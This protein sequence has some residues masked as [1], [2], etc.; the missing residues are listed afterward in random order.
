MTKPKMIIFDYGQTLVQEKG[1]DGVAGTKV[2]L[3]RCVK[4]LI[5]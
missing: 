2:V 4:N 5:T 1:F 3:E